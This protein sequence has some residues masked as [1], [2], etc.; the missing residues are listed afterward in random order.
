MDS[1]RTPLT[2]YQSDIWFAS[3]LSPDLPQFNVCGYE[4]FVGPLDHE[5]LLACMRQAAKCNDALRLRFDEE[6]AAALPMGGY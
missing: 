2:T 5:L 6:N 1:G 3:R 4:Q